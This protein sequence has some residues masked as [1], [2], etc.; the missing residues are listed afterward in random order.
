MADEDRVSGEVAFFFDRSVGKAVP[1]ALLTVGVP[2]VAHDSHYPPQRPVP[3]EL[4]IREQTERGLV[5]VTKDKEIRHRESEVT[6]VR[7][8]SA[9]LLVFTDRKATRLRMLRALM[10][11]WP[12]ILDLVQATPSGPWVARITASGALTRVL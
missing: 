1:A 11:A 8:A 5:L 10:I 4:W 2:T 12:A 7:E 6:A 3:D 9:R